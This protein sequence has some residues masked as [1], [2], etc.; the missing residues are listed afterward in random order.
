MK[1]LNKTLII[2]VR[3]FLLWIKGINFWK[4]CIL[5]FA[6]SFTINGF[7]IFIYIL[8]KIKNINSYDARKRITIKKNR[9]IRSI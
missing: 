4:K 9:K 7:A 5:K 3:K 2:I 6:N 8:K 1:Y